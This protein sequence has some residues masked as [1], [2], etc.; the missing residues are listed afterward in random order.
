M[1]GI[2]N[3]LIV[4]FIDI[5]PNCKMQGIVLFSG[6]DP[7]STSMP[8][9]NGLL[10]AC[11][12][13]WC[14]GV[15]QR[16]WLMASLMSSSK[17]SNWIMSC[18][19]LLERQDEFVHRMHIHWY[20]WLPSRASAP[21]DSRVAHLFIN[22]GPMVGL[23]SL[24]RLSRT[25]NCHGIAISEWSVFVKPAVSVFYSNNDTWANRCRQQMGVLETCKQERVTLSNDRQAKW[26]RAHR[27]K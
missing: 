25:W 23:L 3:E 19:L 21:P 9:P 16:W 4:S 12:F 18:P 10:A 2:Q 27:R 20:T 11:C 17:T 6:L 5:I 7:A 15:G 8:G 14:R 24:Q 26:T 1:A 22:G 13:R